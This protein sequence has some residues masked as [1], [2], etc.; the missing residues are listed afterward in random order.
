MDIKTLVNLTSRAWALPILASLND[1]VP[2]RQAP[3]L[4]AIGA[5]RTA[6][7]HSMDHLIAIGL[8]ERNPGHGHPL[9]PEFRLT[10]QGRIAA[11]MASKVQQISDASDHELLRKT[12]TVPVLTTLH[13]PRPFGD[14]KRCLLS[15]SDRALS[16][17]LQALEERAWI[18]RSV[19]E[20]AR[21]PKPN[22]STINAGT[23]ISRVACGVVDLA[24]GMGP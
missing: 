14:I 4:A 5:G 17:S 18:L 21:P 1:G 2:G 6:F 10:L 19:D 23:K 11:E 3:L 13:R 12:W 7:A 20:M 24:Q 16:Q 8:L 9:R 22:Y 15:I